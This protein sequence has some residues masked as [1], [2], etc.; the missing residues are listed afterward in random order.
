M[1][2]EA[3]ARI[4]AE[5][6][7]QKVLGT[8]WKSRSFPV[9]PAWIA[10]QLGIKVIETELPEEVSGA[11]IKKKNQDPIVV[12][13]KADSKNRQ[14]FSCAHELGHYVYRSS[15]GKEEYEWIDLR[16]KTSGMGTKTEEVYANKFAASL[17]MPQDEVKLL[18]KGKTP[19][20]LMAQYFGVSDDAMNFRLQNLALVS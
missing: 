19:P 8:V 14:R 3:P 20:F 15:E 6:A 12:I 10:S 17:L 11:I 7:A 5:E 13:S 4:S 1:S 16:D 18:H 2:T 9:D